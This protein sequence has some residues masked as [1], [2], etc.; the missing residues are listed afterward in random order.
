MERWLP[1]VGWEG[2]YEV[3]DLGLVR[4]LSRRVDSGR[5]WRVTP[6]TV[7]KPRKHKRTRYNEVTLHDASTKRLS[8]QLVHLLVAKAFVG[9]CPSGM[10]CRHGD[11][12]RDNCAASNLSWSTHLDNMRDQRKHGTLRTAEKHPNAVLTH[13]LIEWIKESPQSIGA[14]AHALGSS[15]ST[16]HRARHGMTFNSGAQPCP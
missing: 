5:G 2:L 1:V 11:G 9:P 14:I 10:E 16:V 3:S 13:E 7:L 6:A 15:T 8:T 4:S 12:D